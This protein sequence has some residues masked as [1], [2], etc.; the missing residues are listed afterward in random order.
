MIGCADDVSVRQEDLSE[1]ELVMTKWD[2]PHVA[3][4]FRLS[5]TGETAA[6][7]DFLEYPDQNT[8]FHTS[9]LSVAVKGSA[10]ECWVKEKEKQIR[11]YCL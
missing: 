4:Q 11:N 10:S 5:R 9:P 2:D 6:W 7:N 8:E 1:P 3:V